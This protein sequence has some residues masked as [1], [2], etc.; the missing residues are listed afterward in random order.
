M[1]YKIAVLCASVLTLGACQIP[2]TQHSTS[3]QQQQV[4]L[5]QQYRWSYTPPSAPR[6]ISVAFNAQQMNIITGCNRQSGTWQVTDHQLNVS[7]LVSTKM[8]CAPDLMQL[9]TFS[10]HLFSGH[11]F[12]FHIVTRNKLAV[13][14]LKDLHGNAY[15]FKGIAKDTVD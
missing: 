12:H 2:Q 10:A 13:L 15:H 5:L 8:A 3:S 9:E 7:P 11:R 4:E 6:A 14:Q 1:H